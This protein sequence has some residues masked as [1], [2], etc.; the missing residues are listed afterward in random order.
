MAFKWYS[1]LASTLRIS[2]PSTRP[3]LLNQKDE[4]KPEARY[5]RR[6]A[7]WSGTRATAATPGATVVVNHVERSARGST[8]VSG[9]VETLRSRVSPERWRS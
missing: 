3:V 1:A 5:E 2:S 6:S 4:K 9:I 7:S 8:P